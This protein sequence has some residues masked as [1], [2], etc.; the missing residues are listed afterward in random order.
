MVLF[1]ENLL[2]LQKAGW[3]SQYIKYADLKILISKVNGDAEASQKFIDI[4]EK[5]IAKAGTFVD[6]QAAK[7]A[8][9]Y[10]RVEKV[11]APAMSEAPVLKAEPEAR[12]LADAISKT[13]GPGF[14]KVQ[15][16]LQQLQTLQNS[17]TDIR[18]FLGTNVIAATKIVKKHDKHV[19]A[20]LA[21]RA[22][23]T[24]VMQKQAFYTDATLPNLCAKV[25]GLVEQALHKC[26]TGAELPPDSPKAAK[27]PASGGDATTE[28]LRTL[29]NW[30]LAG[31]EGET[32]EETR[33]VET[34]LTTWNFKKVGSGDLESGADDT[35]WKVDFK[36][37]AKKWD[38][39]D[40]GEKVVFASWF[41]FKICLALGLLYLFICSLSF[42]ADGFRLVAGKQ[43]GE[44]FAESDFMNN[45][46]AGMMLGVLVTV[47]VQ[48]SST[49]TSIAITM[50]G[51]DLLTVKQGIPIIMGANIGTSVT[52]TIVA[53]GQA[54]D[55]DEFRRAFA[56]AT[57]HDMF[58][59]LTVAVLLPIESATHYLYHLSK[60][61]VGEEDRESQEK[62]PDILKVITKPF[63]KL[64]MQIDKKIINKLAEAKGKG[65]L[66]KIKEYE[67]KTFLKKPKDVCVQWTSPR[68]ETKL[69]NVSETSEQ[70][71]WQTVITYVT[72]GQHGGV[73]RALST[74][75]Q[76]KQ[77]VTAWSMKNVTSQLEDPCSDEDVEKGDTHY[78]FEGMYDTWSDEWAGIVMLIVALTILCSCLFGIVKILRSILKGRIAVWLHAVVNDDFP[79]MILSNPCCTHTVDRT[80]DE[81][82]S[83]EI[84][85]PMQWLSGYLAMAAGFGLTICVQ[86][87]SIT[88]SAL[89]PL[90]GVG[91]I[92]LERMYP[93]VLGANIG[94]T[95]TGLL[96]AL[97]ADGDK[98][99]YT[100]AV[101]YSHLFFNITGIA[102]FYVISPLRALPIE[103]ARAL[104]NVTADYKWFPI[105]YLLVMF[106]ILPGIFMGFALWGEGAVITFSII[107]LIGCISVFT[108]HWMMQN[109]PES[110][111]DKL[112]TWEFLPKPLY[113]LQWYDQKCC[114]KMCACL[115]KVKSKS[116]AGPDKPTA[117][118]LATATQRVAVSEPEPETGTPSA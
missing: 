29:P 13:G 81:R 49:S 10:D 113:S 55:R 93:T 91:V 72:D 42:L 45:P 41:V 43:A 94:T 98:M 100:L 109:R 25:D 47:L 39:M 38:E 15:S 34:Y 105:A 108:L 23:M 27:S 21:K 87:S 79:D 62:P 68:Y 116:A 51:A 33:F 65:D 7:Y 76:V 1:G 52:S 9:E 103:A 99:K 80:T 78:L 46:V 74:R 101:A 110:L 104:G 85:V 111:P 63:T 66:E 36:D 6:K 3:E 69:T 70:D 8:A 17:L 20:G 73:E 95:V 35:T 50:V 58:N 24:R 117:T 16:Y 5:Q 102:I 67:E 56:A 2:T 86:S 83:C 90:V 11:G 48:S 12:T 84:L 106:A 75:H 4:L 88:T 89:T 30:L 59:F 31:A 115:T 53:L 22:E 32:V 112:K 28:A 82:K 118:D 60:A 71:V 37:D 14:G 77:M 40:T 61:L 18:H 54:S 57:V 92:Q 26:Y 44:V 97:A 107:F 64:I 96:A 114:N 19:P